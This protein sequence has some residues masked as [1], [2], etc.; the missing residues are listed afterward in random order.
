M[1][2]I[3]LEDFN[4]KYVPNDHFD[5]EDGDNT[6]ACFALG[7]VIFGSVHAAGWNLDFATNIEQQ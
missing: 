1:D 5:T 6:L 2:S 4:W 7:G 3:A